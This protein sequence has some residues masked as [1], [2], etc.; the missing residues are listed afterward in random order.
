[1]SLAERARATRSSKAARY[2][3]EGERAGVLDVG[4]H[5]A[6][7][8]VLAGDIDGDAEI[9]LRTQQTIG[10]AVALGVGVV[11][12]GDFRQRFDDG[13]SHDVRER[14]FALARDG[15]VLVDHAAVLFHH[16]HRDGALRGGERDEHAGRH[17]L[18]D[19]SCGAAQGLKLFAG[20]GLDGWRGWNGDGRRGGCCSPRAIGAI[21]IRFED[22]LPRFVDG[23]AVV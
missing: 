2:C 8:A 16:L 5:Q 18:G 6:A 19:A 4:D 15:A 21:A 1:M 22:V 10:L 3:V 9:D 17:I 14:D 20:G 12:R 11:E 13:P 7:R 23:G